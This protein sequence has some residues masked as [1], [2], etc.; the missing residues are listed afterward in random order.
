M[1]FHAYR[2]SASDFFLVVYPLLNSD[3]YRQMSKSL[4]LASLDIQTNAGHLLDVEA[5]MYLLFKTNDDTVYF[6]SQAG[7]L[8][9][10]ATEIF[11]SVFLTKF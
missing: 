10:L 11:Q 7:L 2:S 5:A 9:P 8:A 3:F 6:E 1:E 4:T